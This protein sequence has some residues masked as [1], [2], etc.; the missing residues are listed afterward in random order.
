L[1]SFP[2]GREN[3]FRHSRS[4]LP[5]GTFARGSHSASGTYFALGKN[6]TRKPP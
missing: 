2:S 5:S 3:A 4:R 1:E 6:A